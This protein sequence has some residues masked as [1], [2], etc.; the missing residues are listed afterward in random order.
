MKNIIFVSEIVHRD[1]KPEN[2]LVEKDSSGRIKRVKLCDFGLATVAK[3]KIF[4][5][6]GTPTYVAPEILAEKGYG[7][8]VDN[9]A[10]GVIAYILLCGFPPFRSLERNQ[11]ELF[12]TIQRGEF[13]YLSPYWDTV[14]DSARDLID[15][16]IEVSIPKRMQPKDILKHKFVMD[17]NS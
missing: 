14:T 3:K 17:K 16:L 6:C 5:V 12:D 4:A 8:D 2:I 15:N 13:E 1:I 11:D 9:W 10:V 7:L